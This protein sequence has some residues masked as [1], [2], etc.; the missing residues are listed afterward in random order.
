MIL[1]SVGC[2]KPGHLAAR[3]G[4]AK[5]KVVTWDDLTFKLITLGWNVKHENFAKTLIPGRNRRRSK[6]RI[7]DF[8]LEELSPPIFTMA[9]QRI[10]AQFLQAPTEGYED[11]IVV[12]AITADSFE[13]KDGL[14]TL[15]QNKQFFEHDKEDPHNHV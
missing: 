11:A 8:N 5:T 4:C 9:D 13:L 14:L 10:V 1:V 12:P 3:L 15:V 2:Q 6:Q 7:E